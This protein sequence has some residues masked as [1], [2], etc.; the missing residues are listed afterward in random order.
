MKGNMTTEHN[1]QSHM[2]LIQAEK[3]GKGMH[4]KEY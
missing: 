2:D 4:C 1:A 3:E